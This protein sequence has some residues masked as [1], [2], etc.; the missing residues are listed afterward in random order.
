MVL[1]GETSSHEPVKGLYL[2][3]EISFKI[4]SGMVGSLFD[5]RSTTAARARGLLARY[6]V[7]TVNE[8]GLWI[9]ESRNKSISSSLENK[10]KTSRRDFLQT[11]GIL[12]F[13]TRR[14]VRATGAVRRDRRKQLRG[15]LYVRCWPVVSLQR[16]LIR[17]NCLQLL[18][19]IGQATNFAG[20]GR[21]FWG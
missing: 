5:S 21:S 9:Q 12:T 10:K 7:N 3:C 6:A 8:R 1:W 19:Q 2:R 15:R 13:L 17:A 20:I 16:R 18:V 14:A 11:R 4:S